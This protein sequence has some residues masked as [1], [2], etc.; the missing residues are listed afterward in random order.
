MIRPGLVHNVRSMLYE[1]VDHVIAPVFKPV[2]EW[3]GQ[4]EEKNYIHPNGSK[5][6]VHKSRENTVP[7]AAH[8]I[9]KEM[10]E[11]SLRHFRQRVKKGA[12][13][14][15]IPRANL[16]VNP[17]PLPMASEIPAQPRVFPKLP[18]I[19][20]S[21]DNSSYSASHQ[22]VAEF[23]IMAG[24]V[25]ALYMQERSIPTLYRSQDAPDATKAPMDL[26]DQ[27]LAKVDP[28]SG[29]LSFVEQSKIREYLP[30][31]NISLEPGL[32][33][34]MGIANGYTKVTSP[35][36]RYVD[37]ISHWQLKAHFLNRKFPFEKETLERLPMKLRR[38]EKD[39]RMLEQRTNRFWSLEFLQRM[40]TEHPDRVYQ[41]VVTS[42]VDDEHIGATLTDFG[43]QGRLE[44]DGPLPVGTILNVS[45]ANL[46]TYELLFELKPV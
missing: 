14:T 34:S 29:M 12:F 17:F 16:F 43:V 5:P 25:A 41:A 22:M 31:A 3:E 1:D 37:L 36:R 4:G 13:S 8:D 24:K 9:L 15:N 6:L 28:N 20:L 40:R 2:G 45:I 42:A 21:V 27:V 33:W 23:M 30:S 10:Q 44:C 35:L 19:E 7:E 39:M 38:M 18:Q 26:I 32:H 46:N 11:H